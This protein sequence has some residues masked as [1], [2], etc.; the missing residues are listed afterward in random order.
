MIC[1]CQVHRGRDLLALDLMT[2][3]LRVHQSCRTYLPLPLSSYLD[4]SESSFFESALVPP[5]EDHIK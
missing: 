1:N 4:C 3:F 5:R 2:D